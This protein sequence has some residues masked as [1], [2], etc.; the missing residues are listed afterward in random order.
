MAQISF[1]DKQSFENDGYLI[2]TDLLTGD[3]TK[4]LQEWAQEVHDWPTDDS[5]P[6]MPYAEINAAGETVLCRTEN[7]AASHAGLNSLLR[8]PKL[9][10]I[11]RELSG[12]EMVLFKE[13]INYKLAKSGG[14][15]A[16]ID[17]VRRPY[18]LLNVTVMNT[19]DC[20]YACQE[21]QAS[22]HSH[23]RRRF[24]YE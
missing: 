9:L 6:W 10:E 1:A 23:G 18:R 15:A 8:G 4:D 21:D 20:V 14:F 24:K 17:S 11:L 22:H 5:S 16:H 3:E 2:V 13:K 7:Y 19:A 12:E